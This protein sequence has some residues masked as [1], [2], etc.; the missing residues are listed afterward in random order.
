MPPGVLYV[1]RHSHI[2]GNFT[3]QAL[4]GETCANRPDWSARTDM[5]PSLRTGTYNSRISGGGISS[6]RAKAPGFHAEK[7]DD[8][9]SLTYF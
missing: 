7:F 1:W 5:A 8:S 3:Y 6:P 2:L 9:R 4:Q